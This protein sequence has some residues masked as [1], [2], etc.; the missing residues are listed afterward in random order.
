VI[1]GCLIVFGMVYSWGP[2][3]TYLVSDVLLAPDTLVFAGI[4]FQT[5]NNTKVSVTPEAYQRLYALIANDR[6][7]SESSD[8]FDGSRTGRLTLWVRPEG[9]RAAEIFQEVDFP[10]QGNLYRIE[11]HGA[12]ATEWIYF[13]HA[14]I[15][16][17]VN[18]LFVEP[19]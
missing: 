5:T 7:V 19:R 18:Q 15:S 11:R 16:H 9:S 8:R 12:Q 14:D 2:T 3:G 6:S 1:L 13:E 4:E 10:L 17:L